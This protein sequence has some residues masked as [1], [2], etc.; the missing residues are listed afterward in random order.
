ME[1]CG[2]EGGRREERSRSGL[3]GHGWCVW[4]GEEAGGGGREGGEWER[5]QPIAYNIRA[6]TSNPFFFS[7]LDRHFHRI[8]KVLK[9][10]L[11][12]RLQNYTLRQCFLPM[13]L[14][15][16]AVSLGVKTRLK[17]FYLVVL[18]NTTGT[19]F[20]ILCISI[21][22]WTSA[23][24]G[25]TCFCLLR[26]SLSETSPCD[27]RKAPMCVS[28][29]FG[30]FRACRLGILHRPMVINECCNEANQ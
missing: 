13:C 7:G 6:L 15:M 17:Q 21:V 27:M 28:L 22:N 23:H 30:L 29:R 5:R 2:W 3:C 8:R 14:S 26:L 12:W 16:V 18:M 25:I 1:A 4:E 9:C 20:S 10:C 19:V 11:S 24:F